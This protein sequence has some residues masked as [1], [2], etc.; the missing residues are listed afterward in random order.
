MCVDSAS[1]FPGKIIGT[2][3]GRTATRNLG[4]SGKEREDIISL[5]SIHRIGTIELIEGE[6][7]RGEE[8]EGDLEEDEGGSSRRR[9]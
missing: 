9:E 4:C 6:E 7:A 8:V 2:G 5:P 3:T 1:P